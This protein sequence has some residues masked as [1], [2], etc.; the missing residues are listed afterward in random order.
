MNK[1]VRQMTLPEIGPK[2]QEKLKA[3]KVLIVGAGGLGSPAALYLAGAGVGT[4][5][6]IDS[7]CVEE[8][9]LHRQVIHSSRTVGVP[10]ANSAAATISSLN[11]DVKTQAFNARLDEHNAAEIFCDFNLIL[12]CTDNFQ[13]RYAINRACVQLGLPF[14]HGA[15]LR[16]SGE[17]SLFHPKQGTPCYSCVFPNPPPED[18]APRGSV[19]GILG[20]IPGVI[21]TIQALQA[22]KYLAG[23]GEILLGKLLLFDGLACKMKILD[24]KKDAGCKVCG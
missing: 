11:P 9:N 23:F 10:K 19:A 1:Y 17:I 3:A 14:V 21:G 22:V 5:G 24:L 4:I 13:S 16:Y 6:I 20:M 15:I 12:D 7:D 2:G 8:I 18:V